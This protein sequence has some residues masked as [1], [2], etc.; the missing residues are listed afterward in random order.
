MKQRRYQPLVVRCVVVMM[1]AFSYIPPAFA[2]QPTSDWMQQLMRLQGKDQIGRSWQRQ[3]KRLERLILKGK[4]DRALAEGTQLAAEMVYMR[5]SSSSGDI[6]GTVNVLRAIAAYNAGDERQGLWLW[7]TSLQII[8]ELSRYDL[9][10][11][12]EGVDFLHRNPPR[13]D[14]DGERERDLKDGV[15]APVKKHAPSPTFPPATPETKPLEVVVSVIIDEQGRPTSPRIVQAAGD[16][17][18]VFASLEAFGKWE[19]EPAT[20]GGEPTEFITNLTVKYRTK[21]G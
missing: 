18:L 12:G 15:A 20:R 5:G 11:F 3:I 10:R 4:F 17:P 13:A 21:D 16:V 6:L 2:Q 7:Q 14:D 19:F 1:C 9:A 8:P